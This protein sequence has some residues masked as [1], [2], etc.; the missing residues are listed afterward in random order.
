MEITAFCQGDPFGRHAWSGANRGIFSALAALGVL[1]A[2]VDVEVRGPRRYLLALREWSPDKRQWRD[3][4]LKSPRLFRAR[5][6]AAARHLERDARMPDAV[7]QIG[8]MFD[9]AWTYRG[10]PRFCYLDSNTLLSAR[11][12]P[13]A[14]GHRACARYKRIAFEHERDIYQA[15]AGVFVFSDFVRRSL[16]DDF[17]VNP[18]RVHTVY[19]GVNLPIPAAPPPPSPE[20]TVLFIGR[21][22]ARKGGPLLLRAFRRVRRVLPRARLI[23]AGASPNVHQAG[24]EVRGFIDKNSPGGEATLASLFAQARVFTLPSHFEPFGVVYAEAMHF[25]LPCVGVNHCA[26]PEIITPGVTGLLVPPDDEISLAEALTALLQDQT[27]AQRMGAAGREKAQRLFRWEIVAH[28][29]V[30]AMQARIAAKV[31]QRQAVAVSAD[32]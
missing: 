8:A 26:M 20:P 15:S 27:L 6:Q 13:Q 7:L 28:K 10:L 5:T 25:G 22:F 30:T 24:V 16:I 17:G 14:F 2:A 32:G 19:A 31:A 4:F 21:D 1:R 9:A 11:G 3:N 29:M 23:I 12:G 18:S